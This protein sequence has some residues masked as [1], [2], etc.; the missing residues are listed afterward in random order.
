MLDVFDDTDDFV[1]LRRISV[2]HV[3]KN[4]RTQGIFGAEELTL[5]GLIDDDGAR[6]VIVVAVSNVA[7]AHEGDLHCFKIPWPNPAMLREWLFARTGWRTTRYVECG[8]CYQSTQRQCTG[9]A[10]SFYSR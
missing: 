9:C 6:R 8:P 2:A 3:D 5:E 7:S 4:M 10:N 1:I